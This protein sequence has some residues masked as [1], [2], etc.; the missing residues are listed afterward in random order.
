MILNT[1]EFVAAGIRKGA[2]SETLYK[3]M[4]FSA[5]MRDWKACEGFIAEFRRQHKVDTIW[6]EFE[7]LAKRWKKHPLKVLAK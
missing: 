6:Q 3:H 2:Y 7:C 1:H 4:R 5:T